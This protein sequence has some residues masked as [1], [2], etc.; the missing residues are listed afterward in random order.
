MVDNTVVYLSV[1][2]LKTPK[3]QFQKITIMCY[4]AIKPQPIV[5]NSYLLIF[6]LLS[7]PKK[8]PIMLNIM[9]INTAIMPRF[10]YNFVIFKNYLGSR[11]LYFNFY[12]LC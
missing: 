10:I 8:L 4:I 5:L 3:Q 12:Q 6:M 2:K 1:L 9:P 11:L 7:S